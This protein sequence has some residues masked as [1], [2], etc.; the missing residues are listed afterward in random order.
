MLTYPS[1][2]A[3]GLGQAPASR[4]SGKRRPTPIA[5]AVAV[6]LATH[7]AIG[8]YLLSMAFYVA[9]LAQTAPDTPPIDMQT[10]QLERPEPPKP[11]SAPAKSQ[12]PKSAETPPRQTVTAP[13]LH[14]TVA[15][16]GEV[17]RPTFP[18]GDPVL[19]PPRVE[20]Q[21]TPPVITD[22]AWLSRPDGDAISRVYPEEAARRDIA[23]GVTLACRVSAVGRVTDCAVEDETPTGLGFGK[24]ALSLTRY[25][26]MKPRTEDGQP[27][28]GATVHIPIIFRVASD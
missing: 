19:T 14:Q 17:V 3:P 10:V 7:A 20:A 5:V 11:V 25:F 8:V 4:R 28:D 27:V 12:A 2:E 1:F 22:P 26:R 23:G 6:S 13:P 18:I 21:S 9:P 16:V 24:A 15:I